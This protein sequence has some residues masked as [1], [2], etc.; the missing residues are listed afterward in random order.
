MRARGLLAALVV[1][2]SAVL[3]IAP[4]SASA[5][6]LDPVGQFDSP[7]FVTSDPADPDRL[8][9]VEKA[10]TIELLDHGVRRPFLDITDQVPS[11]GE[12]RAALDGLRSRLRDQQALL[13]LLQRRR[14]RRH[15][16]RRVP[17]QR[18]RHRGRPLD[19]AADHHGPAPWLR[20]PQRR[21]A[22][23]RPR[24]LPLHRH[25]RRRRRRRS[26]RQ[27]PEP[28]RRCSA[29]SCGSTPTR[30]RP[31]PGYTIPPDNPFVGVAGRDEIWAYGV[32]NPWRFSFDRLNGD[33]VI[34]DVGQG[35]WEE[36]DLV[37]AGRRRRRGAR[38]SAGT[39]ARA[40]TSTRARS[41]VS[42]TR[43]RLRNRPS[44]TPA[45][46]PAPSSST[47]TATAAARSPA[48]TSPATPATPPTTA[49]TSTPTSAR[50]GSTR[51]CPA[52]ARPAAPPATATR[53]SRSAARRA[54]ARTPA[55]ASTW[56]ASAPAQVARIEGPTPTVC[57]DDPP[58]PPPP[59]PAPDGDQRT[60]P[61]LDPARRRA[62]RMS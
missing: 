21:P 13:R 32:R 40:T 19:A 11:D 62:G 8:F 25:R 57:G 28:G 24:R 5:L 4:G 39:P 49:A 14:D 34:G 12:Q 18:R 37:H 42:R 1:A 33:L 44:A 2:V 61:A 56:P 29:R 17:G 59:P 50:A 30:R 15:Q 36:I 51:C 20:Q 9:V 7:V 41:P 23:V 46:A 16:G 45:A 3:L 38:T 54:S 6:S 52:R 35:A 47:R 31:A 55:A 22:A 48:A 27:R 26:G 58:P 60:L 43:R 53:T 10:G